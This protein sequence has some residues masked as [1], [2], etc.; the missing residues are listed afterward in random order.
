LQLYLE[1]L[2]SPAIGR[3]LKVS[4]VSVLKWIRSFGEKIA[5]LKNEQQS[6]K[7]LKID[8]IHTYVQS[9]KTIF[10]SGL[11]LIDLEKIPPFCLWI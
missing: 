9:K 6:Q 10:G 5:E 8:E 4:N 3:I 1:G 7:I 2:G 11:L